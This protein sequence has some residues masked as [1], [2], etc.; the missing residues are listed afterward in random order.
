MITEADKR[1]ILEL[2]N[3]GRATY[4]ELASRL[5]YSAS[6]IARRIEKLIE[7]KTITVRALP[8]PYRMGLEANAV[9]AIT[10][11]PST[12][13]YVCAQL[14]DNFYINNIH[15][16]FGRIDILT[17]V[18]F[19]SWEHLH[20]FINEE[21]FSINGVKQAETYYIKE[22]RKR[23]QG[24]FERLEPPKPSEIKSI[25]RKLIE[26]LV[27]DGRIHVNELA[28]KLDSNVSTISRRISALIKEEV[29]K[30]CAVPNPAKLGYSS[31]ATMVLDIEADRVDD[32][33]RDLCKVPE[34]HTVMTMIK[35]NGVI[36][37]IH[38]WNNERLYQLIKEKILCIKGVKRT[39]TFIRAEI[40][41]RYY[42][43]FMGNEQ[44]HS[45]F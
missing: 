32:I 8:N 6:T 28:E 22:F 17:I 13:D 21:L 26:A 42:S 14:K 34:L 2:Q 35:G 27:K 12:V 40:K 16:I 10:C 43:W 5:G 19:P 45:K 44:D 7:S 24:L 41:K 9:I 36:V 38:S 11:E 33:C 23:Y 39:E 20:R 4:T 18:F 3:N 31:N 37:G 1:I 29:I 15:T 25:D 30:I